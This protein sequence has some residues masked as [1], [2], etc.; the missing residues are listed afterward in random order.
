[1]GHGLHYIS[2]QVYTKM[3]YN[4]NK[5]LLNITLHYRTFVQNQIFPPP[6]WSC[7]I[8]SLS[9]LPASCLCLEVISQTL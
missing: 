2:K 4:Q 8:A 1:M 9:S 6:Y 7:F 3:V 5:E